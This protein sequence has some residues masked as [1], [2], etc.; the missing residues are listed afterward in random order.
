MAPFLFYGFPFAKN[1]VKLAYFPLKCSKLYFV[2]NLFRR[3]T[4]N[5]QKLWKCRIFSVIISSGL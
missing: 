1:G 2:L 3:N 5:S 4:K